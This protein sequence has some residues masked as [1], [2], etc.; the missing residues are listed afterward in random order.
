[1]DSLATTRSP[2]EVVKALQN[3]PQGVDD[4]YDDTMQRVEGQIPGDRELAKCILS[5]IIYAYRQLSLE[6][7]R[8][9]VAVSPEMTEMDPGALVDET[10]LTSVCAGLVVIHKKSNIV[11][12][13][14]K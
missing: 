1:M 8:H 4:I 11:H 2:R 6:E 12:L 7:L 5:W 9:A 10:I 14:R 13:V 3:M